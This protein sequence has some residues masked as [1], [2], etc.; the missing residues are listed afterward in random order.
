MT[1]RFS[2]RMGMSILMEKRAVI[3]RA[4]NQ[5][6]IQTEPSPVFAARRIFTPFVG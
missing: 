1:A 6:Q 2:S 3:D 5:K 4:H